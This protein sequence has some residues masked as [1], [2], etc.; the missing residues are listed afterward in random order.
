MLAQAVEF[1]H[2][3][4]MNNNGIL[5]NGNFLSD[6]PLNL[7]GCYSE[8]VTCRVTMLPNLGNE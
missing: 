4:Q 5:R 3:F 6:R 7:N 8:V 2:V 1:K